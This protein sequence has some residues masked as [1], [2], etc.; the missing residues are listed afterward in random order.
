M[1]YLSHSLYAVSDREAGRL[2]LASPGNG[3][4]LPRIGYER[5]VV[6]P[7]GH[8]AVLK[9]TQLMFGELPH[10]TRRWVWTVRPTY[11]AEYAA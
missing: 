11:S 9:R 2:A 8:S 1:K 3:G 6:L 4:K 10:L 7:D 5:E